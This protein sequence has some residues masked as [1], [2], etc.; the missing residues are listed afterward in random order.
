MAKQAGKSSR[1]RSAP[2]SMAGKSLVIVESPAKAK[3]IN[4]YL[5]SD[6]VVRAS[7]GHVRDLP[8]KDLGIDLTNGFTPVYETL[9]SRGKVMGELSKLSKGAE[10]VY[11]ATDLDREGEA[12]AWHL[13][14]ALELP[15]DK[16]RR[17]VFNEITKSAIQQA[18]DDPHGINMDRVNAQQ[19][20]RLLD[21]IMGYQL[22][23]LLWR[24]IAKGLSAGRVQSV[25]VRIIVEREREIRA[26]KPEE[27]WRLMGCFALDPSRAASLGEAWSSFL[28]EDDER[29]EKDK[30]AWASENGCL[31]AELVEF[32]GKEFKPQDVNEARRVAEALGYAVSGVHE[33][34][35]A[36]YAHLDLKQCRLDGRVD[37]ERAPAHRIASVTTKRT[38]TKPPG[39]FTTASLQ[40]AASN[41]LRFSASRTMRVAQQLYEGVDI[42]GDEGTVGLITYMRTDSTNLSADSVSAA[43]S[44]LR[45]E[46]GDDYVPDKPNR[47]GSAQRA[48]EA[49]EAIRPS[50]P[51]LTPEDL[52]G[53][54]SS[55]QHRLY[56]LIWRRF[57][58][59]QMPPAQWDST[60]VHIEA[61]TSEG[62]AR[63]KATGRRLIFD[64]FLKI[65]GIPSSSNEQT[66]PELSE[67]QTTP[68]VGIEPVQCFT[69]PPPRY[70]EASLVKTLEA[71]GI[72]RPSTYAAII[73]TIQDRGYVEQRDRKFYATSLGMVVTDKLVEHFPDI[74]DVKFTSHLEDDLDKIAESEMDWVEVLKEFYDPFSRDLAKAGDEMEPAKAEPSEYTC[75]SCGSQMVYRWSKNG[76][77][78][79]CSAYPECKKTQD[80]DAEGKPIQLQGSDATC[81]KCG[82]EMVLRR[83]RGGTFLG[84]SKYPECDH[85]V[86]CDESGQPLQRVEASDIKEACDKCGEPMAVKWRGRRAFLGC[87][88]YPSCKNT[89]PMPE[90]VYVEPPPKE[91]PEPAGFACEKCGSAMVIRTGRRGKFIACSGFPRCRNSKPVEK[92]EELR[93]A[94][95]ENGQALPEPAEG[96]ADLAVAARRPEV[97]RGGSK[98]PAKRDPDQLSGPVEAGAVPNND[99]NMGVRL[100]KSGKLAVD[101]L[102]QPVSCPACGSEMSLKR[103]PWG[104]FLSCTGYPKCR[105][106]GRLNKKAK[107]QAEQELPPAPPKPK[108]KPTDIACDQCGAKMV[109]RTGR[110]GEFLSCSTYPKCK[111]AKPLPAELIGQPNGSNGGG[112]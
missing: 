95:A 56:D 97:R 44:W 98:Q 32:D 14:E 25:A 66:L 79:S 72:G 88:G 103:G 13:V 41:R 68:P 61:D 65:A 91:P 63:F 37:P 15:Q 1:A 93:A 23:P 85:T 100:T 2:K 50:E 5:G 27:Y 86:P 99:G 83:A 78:L 28:A 22:S 74:L 43:R 29:T 67:G 31:R 89:R 19:A 73:Q 11:L 35:W 54:L 57:M 16:V 81:E 105:M 51:R 106:T 64:G 102:D 96:D 71:E 8:K 40:Q 108:P 9:N 24:K 4:K 45:D 20:R 36:D 111:N 94:A 112:S 62:P 48:Q 87:T 76:R 77:F 7:M 17:V 82:A 39:P 53:R 34:E 47:Y 6:Y 38:T 30:L 104:P 52:R 59:C 18:F 3:T 101:N 70:T 46:L 12:I 49:H 55:E 69:S 107:E 92:L 42:G 10:A 110:S 109:I 84:C 21:R 58:A 33:T 90:G 60:A 75:P 26:F 80:V